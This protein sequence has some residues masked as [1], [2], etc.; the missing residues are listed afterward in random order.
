M[1]KEGLCVYVAVMHLVHA[2][3]KAPSKLTS[4][5]DEKNAIWATLLFN[6][7]HYAI[8]P[9]PWILVALS[10]LIVFPN[11]DSLALAFPN[12]SADLIGDDLAYPAM[13]SFLPSGLLGLLIAS[14]IL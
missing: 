13:M 8:R 9:W 6:F 4:R 7:M 3:I 2:P 14:L 5:K 10:S 11:L 12:V 1:S